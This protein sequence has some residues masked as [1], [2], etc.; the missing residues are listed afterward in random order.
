MFS[1]QEVQLNF[2]KM[3]NSRDIIIIKISPMFCIGL[4]FMVL[5]TL[6]QLVWSGWS[7]GSFRPRNIR[8]GS[9]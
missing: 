6:S 5:Q 8:H 1:K 9:R 3:P 4:V 2:L 7:D